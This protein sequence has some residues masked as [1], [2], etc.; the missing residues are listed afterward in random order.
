MVH[1]NS[2]AGISRKTCPEGIS[3]GQCQR[4]K[5][6]GRSGGELK[7]AAMGIPIEGQANGQRQGV[8]GQVFV[9]QQLAVGQRDGLPGKGGIEGDGGAGPGV[10][11]RLPQGLARMPCRRI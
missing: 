3:S 9:N 1:K 7:N 10:R 8:N 4:R 5:G 6:V 2:P 11:D